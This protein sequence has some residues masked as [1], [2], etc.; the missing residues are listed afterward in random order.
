MIFF[1]LILFWIV[2]EKK[3]N[4]LGTEKW[5]SIEV[6][7]VQAGL[8]GIHCVRGPW[9]VMAI[10]KSEVGR[11][12]CLNFKIHYK[13]VIIKHYDSGMNMHIDTRNKTENTE[14]TLLSVANYFSKGF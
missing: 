2:K 10:L 4:S 14:K 1:L 13:D 9:I 8:T 5:F 6:P 12:A 7:V 3:K 11:L